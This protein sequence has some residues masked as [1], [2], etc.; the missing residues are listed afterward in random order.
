MEQAAVAHIDLG[1]LDLPFAEVLKPRQQWAY[2]EDA[3]HEVEVAPH[4]GLVHGE[5]AGQFGGVPRLAMIVGDHA[6]E[7][8]ERDGRN[9][10]TQLRHVS[11]EERLDELLPPGQ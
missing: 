4:S 5:G 7:P 11:F 2:H 6:P 8:P 10:D 1:G 3:R 9:R